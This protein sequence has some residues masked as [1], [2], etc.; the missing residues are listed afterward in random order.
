MKKCPFCA[1]EIQDEAIKCRHCG[2][3]I[4]GKDKKYIKW[5]FKPS[6][7]IISFLCVGPFAL[8]LV[9][10]NPHFTFRKKVVITM[11][12]LILTFLMVV[13]CT[14][15]IKSISEYYQFIFDESG[16]F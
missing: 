4:V 8:P 6:I 14:Y 16:N 11:I 3:Y 15:S 9:L 1:E 13:I 7:I 5:Y 10:L 12:M 2:E